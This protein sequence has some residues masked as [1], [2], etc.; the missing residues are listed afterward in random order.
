MPYIDINMGKTVVTIAAP[1]TETN[2]DNVI[3]VSAIDM[4]LD[5]IVKIMNNYIV[6]DT[7]F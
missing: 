5:S 2:T 4:S 1:I 6:G 3:G 7:G